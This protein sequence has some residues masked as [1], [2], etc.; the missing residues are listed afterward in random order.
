MILPVIVFPG[1][2]TQG[3]TGFTAAQNMIKKSITHTKLTGY[4]FSNPLTMVLWSV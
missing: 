1:V 4:I 3:Q 2:T